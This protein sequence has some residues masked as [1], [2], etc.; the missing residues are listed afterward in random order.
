LRASYYDQRVVQPLTTTTTTELSDDFW[1][2][3]LEMGYR[4]SRRLGIVS[5]DVRNLFDKEFLYEGVD[6]QTGIARQ[7]PIQP[8]RSVFLNLT[9]GF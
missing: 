1:L 7:S 4:L 6:F 2:T 8:G 5:L 9:V 3:D